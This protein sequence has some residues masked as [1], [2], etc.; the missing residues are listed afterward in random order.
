MAVPSVIKDKDSG[1]AAKVS[2]FGQLVVAPLDYSAPVTD[3]L[4]PINTAVNF[5]APE[6]GRSIV[7]TDIIA[8][9]DRNVSNTT[10]SN[11][12]I[13]TADSPT[14]TTVIDAVVSPQ[15]LRGANLSLTGLNM[16][17]GQGVWVNAKTDDDITLLTILFYRVPAED[18]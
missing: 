17:V 8:S 3:S 12:E 13:Y 14:S 2:R 16:L 10:P 5:I 7:I 9:A 18:V 15:L 1:N 11:V 4:T 6:Q